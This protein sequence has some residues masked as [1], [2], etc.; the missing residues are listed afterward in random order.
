MVIYDQYKV[1]PVPIRDARRG[2]LGPPCGDK[3]DDGDQAEQQQ[4]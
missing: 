3:A 4:E 2:P 1:C